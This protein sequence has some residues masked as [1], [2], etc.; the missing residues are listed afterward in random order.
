MK[1]RAKLVAVMF[2]AK[3]TPKIKDYFVEM[4]FFLSPVTTFLNLPKM[5]QHNPLSHTI[6]LGEANLCSNGVPS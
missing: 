6:R 1:R 3:S 5:A 2:T 4:G